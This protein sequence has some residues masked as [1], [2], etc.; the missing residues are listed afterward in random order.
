[1][2]SLQTLNLAIGLLK[3]MIAKANTAI[4][5]QSNYTLCFKKKCANFEM[6]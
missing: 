2:I 4:T 6:V 5:S 1:V 3:Q